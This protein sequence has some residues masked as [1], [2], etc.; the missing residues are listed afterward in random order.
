MSPKLYEEACWSV[1]AGLRD[2]FP[3]IQ[4]YEVAAGAKNRLRGASGAMHQIDVSLRSATRLILI[5]CKCLNR[6]V[7]QEA[8]LVLMGRLQDIR[9]A[10]PDLS[11]QASLVSTKA[12]TGGARTLAKQYGI[13]LDVMHNAQEY[14]I[15]LNQ[16]V[17][18]S[19]VMRAK[20]AGSATPTVTRAKSPVTHS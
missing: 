18:P 10:N 14:C 15:R 8:V 19:V 5:E 7:S 11:V 20:W 16:Y 6:P 12:V 13:E 2:H 9:D 4:E 1:I 3:C 17:F